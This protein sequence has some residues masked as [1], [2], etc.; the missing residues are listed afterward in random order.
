M[1]VYQQLAQT[2]NARNNCIEHENDEWIE[3]HEK[4]INDVMEFAPSGSGIDC[5]T[6]MDVERS[7]TNKLLFYAEY[8]HMNENGFYDGWTKHEIKIIPSLA[9]EFDIKIT[10]IDRDGIK[11][12]LTDVY[13]EWLSREIK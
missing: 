7:D 5:G 11:E 12:Y 6:K 8:H 2:I 13:C 4:T 3:K 9:F 1:K 10:G